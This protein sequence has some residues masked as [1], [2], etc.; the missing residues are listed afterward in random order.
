MRLTLRT[1]LAWLDDTLSPSEVREIG[2]QVAESP[3]AGDLVERIHRVTRQRRLTIPPRT[4]PD[5]ID[6]NIVSS[7]LDNELEPELVAEVEKKCLTS[8]VHLAEV[9]SV[10]QI[11]SLIGQKAKVPGEARHRMYQLVRG[12]ESVRPRRVRPSRDTQ[13]EPVSTPIQPWVAPLPPPRPWAERFG[14]AVLVLSLIALLCWSA[15]MS[16]V[17]RAS[18]PRHAN[19][20]TASPA[21]P[22][23]V[24]PHEEPDEAEAALA[25][26]AAVAGPA[27]PASTTAHPDEAPPPSDAGPPAVAVATKKAE[28][29]SAGVEATDIARADASA[30]KT[31]KAKAE[32]QAPKPE[33]PP[34]A[35]GLARKPAGVLLRFNPDQRQW[36]RL[37]DATPLREQDRLLSLAPYRASVEIG[38]ANVDLV[39][40]TEV[41]ARATPT[42]HAARL[43]LAQGRAVLHGTT[44]SLPFEIQ[45]DGHVVSITPP[46]GVVVGVERLNRRAPGQAVASRPVLRVLA[47]E[48]QV[49]VKSK[50]AE[51]TVDGPGALTVEADGK[52]TGKSV[53]NPPSWV[54]ES[55]PSPF[56]RKVGEQFLEF[57]RSGQ[58]VVTSL[59]EATENKQKDI[60]RLAVSAL[61]SVGDLSL[62]VP[63]LSRTGDPTA[64]AARKSAIAV[65]RAYL[66]QG[67]EAAKSLHEQLQDDMGDEMAATAE[68]L[69]VGYSAKEA[70]EESTYAKLVQLLG[71]TE[72][73]EVGIRELALDNLMTL[74][75]RDDLGYDPEKPGDKGLKA[76][77]DLLRAHELHPPTGP[78]EG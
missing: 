2:K 29:P 1:L 54:T 47:P 52:I 4:G 51:E 63:L 40:E 43:S 5:A 76:W 73:G 3:F 58:P 60:C 26:P 77:R 61:R 69:L 56:E 30:K 75:G 9:A 65:L 37:T 32:T 34:G 23:A 38:A 35:A 42:G 31:A 16:L 41:W 19:L 11:L 62:I 55:E 57:F 13:P 68:K 21:L 27:K 44:P 8:D 33:P 49:K 72:D 74:T 71:S 36:E 25:A 66:A 6:P 17:P 15:W 48:G 12:R 14:P 20:L 18:S 45:L 39:G 24:P 7:Y 53:E 78:E 46:P 67:P 59:V 64:S 22:P 70:A 50:A 10:H 28:P